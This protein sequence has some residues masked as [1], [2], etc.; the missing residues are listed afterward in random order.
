MFSLFSSPRPTPIKHCRANALLPTAHC[1]YW[2]IASALVQIIQFNRFFFLHRSAGLLVSRMQNMWKHNCPCLLVTGRLGSLILHSTQQQREMKSVT[3]TTWKLRTTQRR[4]KRGE[5]RMR[6][7]NKHRILY[8]CHVWKHLCIWIAA[9]AAAAAA[10]ALQCR[11]CCPTILLFFFLFFG[12][13]GCVKGDKNETKPKHRRRSQFHNL[14]VFS[15]L[16]LQFIH[17]FRQLYTK[18]HIVF[19]G[20]HPLSRRVKEK[21]KWAQT[22]PLNALNA[23]LRVKTVAANCIRS[24]RVRN[25]CVPAD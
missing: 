9:A 8:V 20:T 19:R 18:M 5:K 25:N 16:C 3:M 6:S 1:V 13:F 17:V 12:C 21:K 24:R 22:K 10:V 7:R 23:F 4:T 15:S 11:Y 14:M 2:A